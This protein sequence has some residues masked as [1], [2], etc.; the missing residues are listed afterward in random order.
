MKRENLFKGFGL[1]MLAIIA[2]AG[3]AYPMG[4]LE[5]IPPIKARN[6]A[7]PDG[8]F[9]RY[10]EYR[11]G[12][13]TGDRYI[14][15][16]ILQDKEKGEMLLL[17]TED[18]GAD[19]KKA[20]P[21]NFTNYDNYYLISL[22]NASLIERHSRIPMDEIKRSSSMHSPNGTSRI[23]FINNE[24]EKT[25]TVQY[26]IVVKADKDQP[27]DTMIKVN[28]VK[29][30]PGYPV[31][32]MSSLL[33]AGVRVLD[34]NSPG[35]IYVVEPQILREPIPGRVKQ[36]GKEKITTPAGSFNTVKFGYAIADSFIGKLL[37]PMTKES[38]FWIEDSP[39][40]L[41]IKTVDPMGDSTQLE[42][43]SNY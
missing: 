43:I 24:L 42:N 17:Y 31:W 10:G 34:L 27:V 23:D 18:I 12:E 36:I 39:R 14:Y 37:D 5:K 20:L 3:G 33:F 21:A 41:I 19:S 4:N 35:I 38:Y 6:V 28:K 15:S 8:E 7:I 9:L 22:E 40:A 2:A 11:G 16:E 30:K 1:I 25:I 13:K 26:K 29:V 32:E